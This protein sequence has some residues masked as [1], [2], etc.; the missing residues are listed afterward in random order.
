MEERTHP[1]QG[2][3]RMGHPQVQVVVVGGRILNGVCAGKDGEAK[4]APTTVGTLA[5]W[6]SP[7][8]AMGSLYCGLGCV[9]KAWR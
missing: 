5:R 3:Q 7:L 8:P 6:S 1:L 9:D 4:L 2:R